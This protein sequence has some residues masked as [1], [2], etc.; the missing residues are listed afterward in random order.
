MTFRKKTWKDRL[1]EFAGRRILTRISGSADS[2]MVVDVARHEGAVSQPGDAFSESNMNDLEDRIEEGFNGTVD[3]G[4]ALETI[5]ELEANT[6]KGYFADALLVKEINGDLKLLSNVKSTGITAASGCTVSVLQMI[7]IGRLLVLKVRILTTREI[8]RGTV[9]ATFNNLTASSN[10][11]L[12]SIDA[13]FNM[14]NN[15]LIT[16]AALTS[17]VSYDIA[18]AVI[19]GKDS[20][21]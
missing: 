9:V 19:V 5:E 6:E 18:G 21:A 1:A 4:N 20:I 12:A 16:R 13:Q 3:K 17:G 15:E 2:Q 14:V 10:T 8:S 11:P 7:H